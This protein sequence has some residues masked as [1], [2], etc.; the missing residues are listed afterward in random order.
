MIRKS[1]FFKMSVFMTNCSCSLR[2]PDIQAQA[3]LDSNLSDKQELQIRLEH[4]IKDKDIPN[5]STFCQ[6]QILLRHFLTI[7]DL[8]EGP[9][10]IQKHIV[11][12]S[13][14]LNYQFKIEDVASTSSRLFKLEVPQYF[15][16]IVEEPK[17]LFKIEDNAEYQFEEKT[18]KVILG[19]ANDQGSKVQQWLDA[20]NKVKNQATTNQHIRLIFESLL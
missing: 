1:G 17:Y 14:I 4:F 3:I 9:K 2:Y 5:V 20:F 11:D 16:T 13:L 10:N 6:A 12:R 15:C 7:L 8:C 18:V 19:L